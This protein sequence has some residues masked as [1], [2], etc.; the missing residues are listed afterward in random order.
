MQDKVE[1]YKSVLLMK[2]SLFVVFTIIVISLTS[3]SCPTHPVYMDARLDGPLNIVPDSFYMERSKEYRFASV[4]FNFGDEMSVSFPLVETDKVDMG[5]KTLLDE[6]L[7]QDSLTK[8]DSLY[9]KSIEDADGTYIL[10]T[11]DSLRIIAPSH[12]LH[13][14]YKITFFK[15]KRYAQEHYFV[16]MSNDS[17]YIICEKFFSGWDVDGNILKNWEK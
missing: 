3:S 7:D 2:H 15:V 17:T 12:P 13:G 11:K 10:P 14:L 16:R 4:N 1:G 8:S 5:G 9:R 6:D